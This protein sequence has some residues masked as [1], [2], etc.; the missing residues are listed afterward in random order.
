MKKV[1]ALLLCAVM[2]IAAVP[3]TL[4]DDPQ[5]VVG[6]AT[7]NRDDFVPGDVD[8]DYNYVEITVSVV[9]NPGF[10]YLILEKDFDAALVDLG[11]EA[12]ANLDLTEGT[13]YTLKSTCKTKIGKKT[14]DDNLTGDQ[15]I[16]TIYLGFDAIPEPGEYS[17][18]LGFDSASQLEAAGS[19]GVR[20][21]DFTVVPGTV[22]VTGGST[23]L[24]VSAYKGEA[25]QSAW[26]APTSLNKK[27]GGWYTTDAYTTPYEGTSGDAEPRFVDEN[28]MYVVGQYNS[29]KKVARVLST[30]DANLDY[31]EV[32]FTVVIDDQGVHAN[33]TKGFMKVYESVIAAGETKTADHLFDGLGKDNTSGEYIYSMR[34]SGFPASKLDL[35]INVTPYW[36]TADGTKVEGFTR[37]FL[38][39]TDS[40]RSILSFTEN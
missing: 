33:K 6:S 8:F 20:A 22:T 5:I 18:S 30:I 16:L 40:D 19:A 7:F 31:Q 10:Q 39:T 32:G 11:G 17:V 9:N 1:L 23:A 35:I 2:M 12:G 38:V 37:Q 14:Y 25:V 28:L 29:T 27:F 21:V 3:V 13:K 36:V 34:L 24:D 4:A 26:T 15:D